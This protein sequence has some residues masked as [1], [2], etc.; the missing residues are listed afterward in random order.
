MEAAAGEDR[1]RVAE[2][3]RL[4]AGLGIGALTLSPGNLPFPDLVVLIS[5]CPTLGPSGEAE[6]DRRRQA[7]CRGVKLPQLFHGC[8]GT[9]GAGDCP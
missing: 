4:T 2:A 5:D 7:L 9:R 6:A 3:T 8:S 1:D